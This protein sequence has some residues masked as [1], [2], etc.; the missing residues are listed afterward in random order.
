MLPER[1]RVRAPRS[2]ILAA[3]T[4]VYPVQAI[5]F[6][7]HREGLESGDRDDGDCEFGGVVVLVLAL[8]R[9]RTICRHILIQARLILII[10][11]R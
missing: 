6:P 4:E 9:D 5:D 2:T 3:T 1:T 8:G 11:S 10:V 7:G